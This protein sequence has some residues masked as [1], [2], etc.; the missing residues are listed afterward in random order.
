MI[1]N[2]AADLE[3]GLEFLKRVEP[4]FRVAAELTGPLQV[5]RRAEGFTSLLGMIVSQQLSVAA[6]SSVWDKLE[7]AKLTKRCRLRKCRADDLRNCGLSKQK[8]RYAKALAAENLNY[9]TLANL[10]DEDMI[11]RLTQI[12]GIGR[13]TAE[14]YGMFS[15]GR[16]DILAAGDLALCE[17]TRILFELDRRPSEGEMRKLARPWSPWRTIAACQLWAYYREIKQREGIR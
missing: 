5:R 11:E 6:A 15:L 1:I 10:S 3:P 16:A 7:K 13:W 14:I 12:L 9:S 8:I 2:G 4:R 17:S